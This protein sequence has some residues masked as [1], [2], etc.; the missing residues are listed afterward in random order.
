MTAKD[1]LFQLKDDG[2]MTD[3]KAIALIN[4]NGGL[5]ENMERI[6]LAFCK[7]EV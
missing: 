6:P 3:E 1:I 7:R 4:P 5:N 2:I